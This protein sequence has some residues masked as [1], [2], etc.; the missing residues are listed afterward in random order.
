MPSEMVRDEPEVFAN[1]RWGVLR[2]WTQDAGG[3]LLV[4]F[5]TAEQ[6]QAAL[7]RERKTLRDEGTCE[8]QPVPGRHNAYL[9]VNAKPPANDVVASLGAKGTVMAIVGAPGGAAYVTTLLV[10]QL[11]RLP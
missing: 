9:C 3:V 5:G 1:A 8:E 11:D 7:D 4:Q 2:S 10:E 6:A